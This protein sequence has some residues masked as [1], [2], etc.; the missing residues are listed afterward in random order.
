[1]TSSN[2]KEKIKKEIERCKN[3]PVYFISKYV[4]VIHPRRGLVPFKLY[5]FQEMIIKCLQENRFNIIRK[6]R[7]AGITTISAAYSLHYIIFNT[8]KTVTILSIGDAESTDVLSRVVEMYDN[9]PKFLKPKYTE[10]NKHTLKLS[11]RSGIVSKPSGKASGRG[12][13]ASLLIIDEAAF[14]ENIDKIWA[15]AYP[16]ISTGGSAFIIS[17]VNGTG[18]WYHQMYS[19]AKANRNAFNAIDINWRDHPEY[20]RHEGYEDLYKEMEMNTPPIFIDDWEKTTRTNIGIRRWNQEYEAEFLGTGDTYIDGE[21]LHNLVEN[22][23]E[24]YFIKYNN[25]M[26][27]WKEPVPHHEYLIAADTGLGRGR[28]YS[29]F[30]VIDLYSG[31]QVAEF[32]SNKTPINEFAKVLIAE[33][34]YY[35]LAAILVERNTIGNTLIE[36]LFNEHEYENVML[37]PDNNFGIQVTQK[38]RDGILADL[39]EFLRINRLKINSSRTN[40]E[41]QTFIVTESG[42]AEADTGQHDD[43]VMSL[44][45]ACFGMRFLYENGNIVYQELGSSSKLSNDEI[46][47][48][49][50][51]HSTNNTLEDTKW[52]LS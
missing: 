21:T 9:L 32:Y 34:T 17:T 31:E 37:G 35:N 42:K 10:R 11:T 40:K 38:L 52:I 50:L 43:L 44:A 27:V 45:I 19:E 14:I 3:D 23:N 26:R 46:L 16:I 36:R 49:R 51:N 18:N 25:R 20:N 2:N 1:M 15:S 39:E 41:L 7:Q 47:F 8:H 48:S 13:S 12:I 6:F 28:D 5:P 29:A 33:G 30:H 4:K 22:E 24:D